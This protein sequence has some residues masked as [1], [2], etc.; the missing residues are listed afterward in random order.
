M[1]PPSKSKAQRNARS[2]KRQQQLDGGH[3][4][5]DES[6]MPSTLHALP[7]ELQQVI[8]NTFTI[9]FPIAGETEQ[10]KQATQEVKGHLFNRDF[11]SAF[12]QPSYLQAYALRWSAARALGYSHILTHPSRR[13]LLDNCNTTTIPENTEPNQKPSISQNISNNVASDSPSTKVICIGGGAGAEIIALAAA[14]K[15]FN[16]KTPLQITAI[17]IA[18]WSTPI[19][20]LSSALSTPPPLSSYAS[21]AAKARPENNPLLP[22]PSKPTITFIHQDVLTWDDN[23]AIQ[24]TIQNTTLCTIMFTLNELFTTSLPKTTSFLLKLTDLMSRH[25]HLLVVDSPGSYSEIQLGSSKNPANDVSVDTEKTTKKKY[26]MKW[27]LDHTLL[28]V[29]GTGE[30]AK[31]MK[32]EGEDSVWYRI[33]RRRELR[34]AVELES[35]RYQLHLYR[36][37]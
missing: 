24:Q 7:L 26:P 15:H 28:S 19:T 29:A 17:D 16:F 5:G 9:A 35:M 23:D 20:N 31:W 37:I 30:Q 10:L 25:S 21:E 27:L 2:T 8:L 34:Y 18:N 13:F 1:A 22:D 3:E 4:S 32:V 6:A 36:R 33:E 11:S 14:Q 12:G